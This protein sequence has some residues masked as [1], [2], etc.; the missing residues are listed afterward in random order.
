MKFVIVGLGSIGKRHKNNL[1]TLGH[2]VIPC[3]QNDD[4]K[5]VL[6][7]NQPNGVI[8]CNPN[9]LHLSTAL[10][11]AKANYHIF[12]E[13]PLS[14]TLNGVEKLLRLVKN[15]NLVL[16]IGYNLR[17]EPQLNRIKD[18]IGDR[19]IGKI[20]SAKMICASYLPNWRPGTDYRLNYSA[21]KRLG[22]GV[23]LD[24][25]HEIDYAVWLFGKVKNI[26]AKLQ[27][28][29]DLDIETEAIADLTVNFKSGVTVTFHLD[30]ITRGYIRNCQISGEK[31]ILKW[32]FA[33][34][35]ETWDIN[36]MYINEMKNFIKS[37]NGQEQPR[38][39]GK[40]AAYVLEIIEAA[41]KS[42][43]SG[44]IEYI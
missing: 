21:K 7:N 9:S 37:I 16:Q 36:K 30:Y 4:L 34:I 11:A 38:V 32:D 10:I 18:K 15:K 26:Y 41:N 12:I 6:K 25:S 28:S 43:Q 8:I 1:E 33:K 27:K 44:K 2:E 40:E 17:F 39:T 19:K 23:L 3:R 5:L 22:G 31:G 20:M 35:K 24:L 14:H 29:V 42:N 13:K